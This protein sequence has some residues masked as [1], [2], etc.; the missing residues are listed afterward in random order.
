M[1]PDPPRQARTIPFGPWLDGME[2]R[3]PVGVVISAAA[4]KLARVYIAATESPKAMMTKPAAAS[5]MS[6]PVDVNHDVFIGPKPFPQAQ[7][8][9]RTGRPLL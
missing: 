4:N 7:A 9:R 8:S 1:V 5:D 2:R 3:A 6:S